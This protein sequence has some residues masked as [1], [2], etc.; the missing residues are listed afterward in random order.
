L[1]LDRFDKEDVLIV[2]K[3][4]AEVIGSLSSILIPNKEWSELMIYIFNKTN[5]EVLVD[6]QLGMLLLSVIIE[7]FGPDEI[8]NY[9]GQL[10]PTIESYLRADEP[11]LKKLSVTTVNKLA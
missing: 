5:S 1:L 9:Y 11:H 2:K 10:N 3:N 8:E 4:I 6:K 7:Y